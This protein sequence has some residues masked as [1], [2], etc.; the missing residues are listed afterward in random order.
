MLL[1]PIAIHLGQT[2]SRL[3]RQSNQLKHFLQ[4]PISAIAAVLAAVFLKLKEPSG[5]VWQKAKKI[6]VVGAIIFLASLIA[7]QFFMRLLGASHQADF[8]RFIYAVAGP[9]VAPFRGIFQANSPA[10]VPMKP[11]RGS[12]SKKKSLIP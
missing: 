5:S 10:K 1:L 9:L 11:G 2:R 4:I 7:I 12:K 8:V 3:F 6:D